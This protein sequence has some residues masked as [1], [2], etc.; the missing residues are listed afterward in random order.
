MTT[1]D[2]IPDN[3]GQGRLVAYS[4]GDEVCVKGNRKRWRV[5]SYPPQ[6][7]YSIYDLPESKV[8]YKDRLLY[9]AGHLYLKERWPK[10]AKLR[11]GVRQKR[12][13]KLA[14]TRIN[15]DS[16]IFEGQDHQ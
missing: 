7:Q 14:K 11:E 6:E 4:N 9:T 1:T 8:L 15:N 12:L 5:Y 3:I 2:Y 10:Y 13:R 16:E